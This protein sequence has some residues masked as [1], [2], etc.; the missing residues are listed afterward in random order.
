MLIWLRYAEARR[1]MRGF[2]TYAAMPLRRV[3][4]SDAP[5]A[6]VHAAYR[7]RSAK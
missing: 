3:L 4:P 6:R 1:L 5:Y 2:T 7:T